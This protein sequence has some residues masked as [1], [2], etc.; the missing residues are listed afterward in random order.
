MEGITLV[1]DT[2]IFFCYDTPIANRHTLR[3]LPNDNVRAVLACS[4][5]LPPGGEF[6]EQCDRSVTKGATAEIRRKP[7]FASDPPTPPA[8]S[9]PSTASCDKRARMRTVTPTG[10]TR[11]PSIYESVGIPR[12][13]CP[14]LRKKSLQ[15]HVAP[16]PRGESLA[17]EELDGITRQFGFCRFHLVDSRRDNTIWSGREGRHTSDCRRPACDSKLEVLRRRLGDLENALP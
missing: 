4:Q 14:R 9:K 5:K 13:N 11:L 10:K 2:K 12:A 1:H 17:V 8:F 7:Y 16:M 15:L 3:P 6:G